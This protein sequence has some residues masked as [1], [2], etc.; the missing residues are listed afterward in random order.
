MDM[1][2]RTFAICLLLFASCQ[3]PA[4]KK[5]LPV[6]APDDSSPKITLVDLENRPIAFSQDK[7]TILNLWATWCKPCIEEMPAL[8]EMANQLPDSFELILAS[9]EELKRI[10]TF[11]SSR[12]LKLT[13]A[14]LTSSMEA[15]G[16]YSL[17]TTL[18][19]NAKGEILTTLVGAHDWNTPEQIDYIKTFQ[20]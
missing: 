12:S 4:K 5:E 20:P 14:R 10:S 11:T 16:V 19:I 13:F 6:S 8:E 2:I 1:I 3:T 15:L 7:I 17:P 9:D 18:I